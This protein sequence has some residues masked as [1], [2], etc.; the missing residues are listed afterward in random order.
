MTT[1][2]K[3]R[4][5]NDCALAALAMALGAQTW[6]E[7]WTEEDLAAVIKSQ[8]VGNVDY[9]LLRHGL[10]RKVHFKNI[11]VHG[12]SYHEDLVGCLWRRRALLSVHS[13]NMPE[14]N[15]MVYWDGSEVFDPSPK[16]TY[17]NLR[18]MHIVRII[19]FD[20][21]VPPLSPEDITTEQAKPDAP[22][23]D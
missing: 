10:K 4:S 7:V 17:A 2:I 3:Q 12:M 19:L 1:L 8:G 22:R 16:R 5:D 18:S 13:L 6:D 20:D 9:W 21:A 11:Y 23:M 14:G 15:H